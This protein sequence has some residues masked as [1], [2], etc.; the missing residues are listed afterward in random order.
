MT[1]DTWGLLTL[2][3]FI[4]V[5]CGWGLIIIVRDH[6]RCARADAYWATRSTLAITPSLDTASRSGGATS[7]RG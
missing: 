1:A 5:M 4:A 6:Q 2:T 3:L 7:Q